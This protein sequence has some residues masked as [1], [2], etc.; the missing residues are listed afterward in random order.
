M[1]MKDKDEVTKIVTDALNDVVIPA[2]EGVEER[3]TEKL[4]STEDLQKA[5]HDLESQI[6][7]LDRKFD[8]HFAVA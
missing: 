5:K 1:N 3:L 2:I 4:A 8:S 6:D 7:T